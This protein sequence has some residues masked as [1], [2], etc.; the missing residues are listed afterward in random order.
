MTI[1][2]LKYY[3]FFTVSVIF[4]SCQAYTD[5]VYTVDINNPYY[6]KA[7]I[8]IPELMPVSG[9]AAE[10]K[11]AIKI[12]E[13]LS[14][15]LK[16]TG[17][18]KMVNPDAFLEEP[19]VTGINKSQLNFRNWTVTGA[20]LLVTGNVIE[21]GGRIVV[22]L[23]LF[24]TFREERL[25]GKEYR[26]TTK[27]IKEI[28]RRFGTE[29]MKKFTGNK[30]LFKSKIAFISTGTKNK[31][32]YICDFDGT[33][34]RRLTNTQSITLSPAWSSNGKYVAYTSY[35]AGKP[36]LYVMERAN[37]KINVL[38]SR[39]GTNITPAWIPGKDLITAS[40]SFEGDQGIYLLTRNG[41]IRKRL[42]GKWSKWGIDV[43]PSFSPDGKKMVFVSKRS[44]TP[45]LYIQDLKNG[46]VR[47]LTYE[48]KYNTS[49]SWS[50]LGDKIAYS[51]SV[52]GSFEIFIVGLDG[53]EPI[54]LT[55]DAGDNESPSWA[56]DGSLIAFSSTREGFSR[57]YIMN[58]FGK[59]Q[60]RL[61][62]I[63]GQQTNPKWSANII[64]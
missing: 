35:E 64:K 49:P 4:F 28:V 55:A 1:K 57:I 37:G 12:V 52:D 30:G 32:V 16:F 19:K 51:S 42:T 23:Q 62:F 45:Q 14:T 54:Q 44:G 33:T 43:S 39:K 50:P 47:R 63:S 20:E 40:L 56:P 59:E 48:G 18:F 34:P 17:Y 27:S 15:I 41:K 25:V 38:S 13:E 3:I 11:L 5:Q 9:S 8:A 53:R 29:I 2:V 26:G 10:E 31:E 58:A 7:P 60:R 61:L 21:D 24:D 22:E 36:D 6:K 46:R